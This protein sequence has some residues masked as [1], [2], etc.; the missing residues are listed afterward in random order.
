MKKKTETLISSL[1]MARYSFVV[2]GHLANGADV[3]L[4]GIVYARKGLYY[5]AQ[6]R[7]LDSILKEIPTLQLDEDNLVALKMQTGGGC[8]PPGDL[9]ILGRP[10][11]QHTG[12]SWPSA[13]AALSASQ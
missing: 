4:R 6:A 3:T 10:K 8:A 11:P 1:P 9:S 12:P 7:V 2:R 13:Q 5:Q